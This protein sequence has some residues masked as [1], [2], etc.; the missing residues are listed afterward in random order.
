[1][2]RQNFSHVALVG[3]FGLVDFA[4]VSEVVLALQLFARLVVHKKK[5]SN[6]NKKK[7]K[8]T[9]KTNSNHNIVIVPGCA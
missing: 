7:S 2:E 6:N 9:R 1:M 5:K 8:M 3:A 4:K